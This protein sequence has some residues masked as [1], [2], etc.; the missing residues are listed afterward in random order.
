MLDAMHWCLEKEGQKPQSLS[1]LAWSCVE[2]KPSE[3]KVYQKELRRHL[4]KLRNLSAAPRAKK[5]RKT[6]GEGTG[7]ISG[8][9]VPGSNQAYE[10][11]FNPQWGTVRSKQGI[12][13]ALAYL[14]IEFLELK[15]CSRGI[16]QDGP[17]LSLRL[18]VASLARHQAFD[19]VEKAH[20]TR[21]LHEEMEEDW[22]VS[23]RPLKCLEPR[24]LTAKSRT[25]V[26]RQWRSY[27]CWMRPFAGDPATH[28]DGWARLRMRRGRSWHGR[29]TVAA[30]GC[31]HRSCAR[32]SSALGGKGCHRDAMP[33]W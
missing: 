15:Q 20:A 10:R 7:V 31:S 8:I 12:C 19:E 18:A 2:P 1:S 11:L 23:C 24:S 3:Q 26:L 25:S 9:T 22:V 21:L 33:C 5:E 32:A 4:S 13:A 30:L 16:L 14:V 17:R 28:G 27:A 29:R 6:R